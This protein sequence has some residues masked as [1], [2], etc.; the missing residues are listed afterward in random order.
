M[1]LKGIYGR[2]ISNPC[3]S[4]LRHKG[5]RRLLWV[6]GVHGLPPPKCATNPHRDHLE[7]Q[8]KS[9]TVIWKALAFNSSYQMVF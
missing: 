1:K 7:Q 8:H 2:L 5:G 6:W 4:T 9:N 3:C